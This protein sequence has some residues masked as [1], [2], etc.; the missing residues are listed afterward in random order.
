MIRVV[1]FD[2]GNTLVDDAGHPFAHVVRAL[3]AIMSMRSA[4]GKALATC[5]V[6][7]FTLTA[8]PATAAKVKPLFAQYLALLDATGLWPLFE[9]VARP[10]A[11][12]VAPRRGV[13]ASGCRCGIPR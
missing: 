9:P 11:A 1:M 10:P 8:P 3:P 12:R 4:G 13:C 7:D 5:L 6:S 2:L